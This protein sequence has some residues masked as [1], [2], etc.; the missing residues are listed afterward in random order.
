[1][2]GP[3][4]VTPGP[5]GVGNGVGVGSG[6]GVGA[7]VGVAV[8]VGV[9]VGAGVDVG[10]GEAVGVNVFAGVGVEVGGGAGGSPPHA[11]ATISI[12]TSASAQRGPMRAVYGPRER[13]GAMV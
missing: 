11:I 1:M 3:V 6:V 5:V 10:V 13:N 2:S 7:A 12:A 4:T 9:G 8:G